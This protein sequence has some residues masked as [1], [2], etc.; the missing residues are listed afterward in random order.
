LYVGGSGPDN[1]TKIRDA[2]NDAVSGDTVFVYNDSS[3]YNEWISLPKSINLIGEDK[4]TTII[5][6]ENFWD[7]I[8][9]FSH[10]TVINGFTISMGYSG[11]TIM[12]NH[13]N[14]CDNI[15]INNKNGISIGDFWREGCYNTIKHNT[16]LD[17]SGNG[18]V[19]MTDSNY[20]HIYDNFF[21]SCQFGIINW[22]NSSTKYNNISSNTITESITAIK[23]SDSSDMVIHENI[24][25]NNY[26]GIFLNNCSNIIVEKNTISYSYR[27]G[28]D[29]YY[30]YTN[31]IFK[32]K[33]L[34]NGHDGID[35]WGDENVISNNLISDNNCGIRFYHSFKN[36]INK[37]NFVDNVKDGTFVGSLSNRWKQNYW[38][39]PRI[40]P[41]LIFGKLGDNASVYWLN[42]DWRP[43]LK[44]YDI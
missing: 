18:I 8:T 31:Y 32:N 39:R 30:S 44:P 22:G 17:I 3:P 34:N 20:N 5:E 36:I 23:L 19:L 43:A 42:I 16:F 28:I 26:E 4:Y 33:I 10:N 40:F 35:I 12:S 11:I 13:N 2:I 38:D 6:Y 9:I 27:D 14:I 7:V 41:K 25:S 1:Y 37:N 15:F 21:K 29:I 24:L